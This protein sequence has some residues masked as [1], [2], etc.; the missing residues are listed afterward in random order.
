MSKY[1]QI[2]ISNPNEVGNKF[3]TLHTTVAQKLVNKLLLSKISYRQYQRNHIQKTLFMSPTNPSE[4]KIL[5]NNLNGSKSSNI[6]DI[7][8][9]VI[10]VADPYISAILSDIFNKSFSSGIFARN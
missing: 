7:P 3:N 8:V 2:I 1:R 4:V 5:I 6:Y 10:K 9:K